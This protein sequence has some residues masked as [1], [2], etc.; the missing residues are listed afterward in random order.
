M[1]QHPPARSESHAG[2]ADGD[3]PADDGTDSELTDSL[4]NPDNI[5][6]WGFYRVTGEALRKIERLHHKNRRALAKLAENDLESSE[7]GAVLYIV[8]PCSYEKVK[9][10]NDL[11]KLLSKEALDKM[12][13]MMKD[14]FDADSPW[15]DEDVSR[16]LQ[17]SLLNIMLDNLAQSPWADWVWEE[18]YVKPSLQLLAEF[19]YKHKH[20]PGV[21]SA[22]EIDA[23]KFNAPQHFKVMLMYQEL[24]LQF[25]HEHSEKLASLQRRIHLLEHPH[26]AEP[27]A[28]QAEALQEETAKLLQRA[29]LNLRAQINKVL[30]LRADQIEAVD[31]CLA[32]N[33]I[34]N[35]PTGSGKTLIS[36]K[37]VDHFLQMRP[38]K[39]VVFVVPTCALVRQQA[40][41]LRTHSYVACCTVA[42]L[43][44]QEMDGWDHRRWQ[45]CKRNNKVLLGTPEIFRSSLVDNAHL[46]VTDVSLCVFDECHHATGNSPMACMLRDA[47]HSGA[48]PRQQRPRIV[49]L[50]ASFC[51]GKCDKVLSFTC[52]TSTRVQILTRQVR[53]AQCDKGLSFTCFTSTR[54]QILTRQVRQAHRQAPRHRGAARR[55]HVGAERGAAR[56]AGAA[57]RARRR[58]PL[59]RQLAAPNE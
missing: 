9:K 12:A 21:Q 23:G 2:G 39:N 8:L 38:D 43:C 50:T 32:G 15:A 56:A 24:Y 52:F 46:R 30:T 40:R 25:L 58:L 7:M 27:E 28:L 44:G 54:V 51:S 5:K 59:R 18:D 6:V 29:C 26:L 55:A 49:G 4:I 53:Q 16:A 33:H 34:I 17:D 14:R 35:M 10:T 1:P 11:R 31:K 20:M 37:I 13:G 41:Y 57:S 48:V 19:A 22:K 3:H 36:V 47:L 45:D 42:E